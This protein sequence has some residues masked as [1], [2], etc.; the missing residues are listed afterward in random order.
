M[1]KKQF[2]SVTKNYEFEY[3]CN[4]EPFLSNDK[5]LKTT[6]QNAIKKV[7]NLNPDESTSG[8]T[9]DARFITKICSVIEFGLVGKTM[10]KIDENIE[11]DD[12]IKLT[13]IYLEFLK[14]YFGVESS[15]LFSS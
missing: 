1:I 2:D 14:N 3:F 9:S 7:V 11:V 8:G 13:E 15:D 10:H 5:F 6:L 12:L 4:A